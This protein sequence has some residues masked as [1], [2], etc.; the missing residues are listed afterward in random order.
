MIAGEGIDQSSRFCVPRRT[1]ADGV[2]HP[3]KDVLEPGM[4]KYENPHMCNVTS[5]VPRGE[6]A[7]RRVNP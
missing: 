2:V 3:G 5:T 7:S 4:A 1:C 6:G